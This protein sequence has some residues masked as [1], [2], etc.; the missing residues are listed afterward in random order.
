MVRNPE[1]EA[2]LHAL[3]RQ[4]DQLREQYA[5]VSRRH[6]EARTGAQL[7]ANRQ[8][9]RFEILEPALVPEYPVGPNRK[10]IVVFGAAASGGLAVGLMFL[11]QMLRPSIYTSSQ[12][13]RELELRPIVAIPYVAVPGERRRRIARWAG[14]C[15][16]VTLGLWVAAF[17]IDPDVASIASLRSRVHLTLNVGQVLGFFEPRP[18]F[19]DRQLDACGVSIRAPPA[20]AE[21]RR[22]VRD[23]RGSAYGQAVR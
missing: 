13:E 14:V 10:K 19:G 12:M 5:D 6:V 9:E 8:S 22:A 1:V 4:L 11:L 17:L 16:L 15:L 18:E 2:S 23:C 20:D 3:E 7:E 21:A